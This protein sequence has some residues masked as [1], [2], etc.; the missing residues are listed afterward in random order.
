L[1]A[2]LANGPDVIDTLTLGSNLSDDGYRIRIRLR[3]NGPV[4]WE[5]RVWP[6][7]A[8]EGGP[9]TVG[10]SG[11]YDDSPLAP[12]TGTVSLSA[13]WNGPSYQG[14]TVQFDDVYICPY[15]R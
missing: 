15:P 5:W 10:N 9:E 14:G 13:T 8:V 1:V 4:H 12:Q 3:G 11:D 7:G 2:V 6:V